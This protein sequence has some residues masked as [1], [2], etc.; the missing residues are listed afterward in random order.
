[1]AAWNTSA[2]RDVIRSA[3]ERNEGNWAAAA[4]ESRDA[5]LEARTLARAKRGEI[6]STFRR[7]FLDIF[8]RKLDPG[9]AAPAPLSR[10]SAF[11]PS[12]FKWGKASV[13]ARTSMTWPPTR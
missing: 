4:R 8:N 1:M 6:E 12:T 10:A 7:H 13:G 3:V 9:A 2:N 5:Y 11:H